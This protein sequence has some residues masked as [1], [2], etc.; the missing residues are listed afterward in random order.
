MN[1]QWLFGQP[2]EVEQR[3]NAIQRRALRRLAWRRFARRPRSVALYLLLGLGPAIATL[4]VLAGARESFRRTTVTGA[5]QVTIS[6]GAWWIIPICVLVAVL[7]QIVALRC[8][9]APNLRRCAH[10]IGLGLCPDCGYRC[11]ASARCPE[12][13]ADSARGGERP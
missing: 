4:A 6:G 11:G 1:W 3:L 7:G 10:E 8:L 2:P 9:Y 13:G 5:N 12:C